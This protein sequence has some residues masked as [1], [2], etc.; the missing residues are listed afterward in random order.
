[1]DKENKTNPDHLSRRDFIRL[2]A[3][4]A[5]MIGAGTAVSSCSRSVTGEVLCPK[6]PLGKTGINASVVALGG[7]SAL[8]AVETEQAALALIDFARRKGINYFDSGSDYDN[9]RSQ[10]RIGEALDGHR[11]EVYLSTKYSANTKSDRLMNR[12]EDTLKSFRTDYVDVANIHGLTSLADV[13]AMFTSGALET[14]TKMKEQGVVRN[15]G[16]TSHNNPI[17]LAEALKRFNFDSSLH[18]ANA[19]KVPFLEEFEANPGG[20]FEDL[21]IPLANQQGIGVWAF[22]VMGQRRLIRKAEEA[23]KAPAIELMRYAMSLPVHGLVLGMSKEKDVTDAVELAA[24]FKP[25]TREEM[26][27]WNQKLAP[28][29]NKLTLNYLRDDYVDDGG[30]RAHLALA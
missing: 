12:I 30:W 19:S 18:A 23:D 16:V 5:A 27:A 2:G 3:G 24:N 17:A 20:T 1:M 11:K 9:G 29:A 13:E 14:L 25:M 10:K 28:N 7:G 15:I 22:K 4:A 26:A 6:S 21:S 8:T